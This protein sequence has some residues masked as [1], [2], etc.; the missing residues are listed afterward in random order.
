MLHRPMDIDHKDNQAIR[1]EIGQRLR[2]YLRVEPKLSV[3]LRK[4]VNL[5]YELEGQ[6]PPI[7]RDVEHGSENNPSSDVSGQDRSRFTWL[8]R[9][10]R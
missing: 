1:R 8:W 7:V 5:L 6:S 3:S 2:E 10:R 4:L 9:P